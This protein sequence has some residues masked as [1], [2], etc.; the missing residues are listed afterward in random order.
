MKTCLC[1]TVGLM[2][3]LT[4][5]FAQGA[6]PHP[7]NPAALGVDQRL[8]EGLF[9]SPI[10]TQPRDE[11]LGEYGVWASG[12]DYKVSF[13]DG[14]TFFPLVGSESGNLPWRW[15]TTKIAV[16][17][18]PIA[19]VSRVECSHG[20]WRYEYRFPGITEAYDVLPNAV[21]Q[22]FV[23][24]RRPVGTGDLTIEGAIT[25]SLVAAPVS[26][27]VQ[28]L[29]F[30]D[31]GGKPRVRYG[32]AMAIAAD[33]TSVPV[34]TQ[35]DGAR[36][37]LVVPG[38]WLA[39]AAMPVVVDP[40][41]AAI[42]LSTAPS[43]ADAQQASIHRQDETA[44]NTVVAF[45]RQFA[46]GDFDVF[47]VSCMADMSSPLPWMN[48]LT[49]NWSSMTP[50]VT[51]VAG[52]DRWVVTTWRHTATE[53]RLRAYFHARDDSALNSGTFDSSYNPG[54]EHVSFPAMG[55]TSHPTV[56]TFAVAVYRMD[57]FFGNSASS[58]IHA[59]TVDA[60]NR[61]ITGRQIVEDVLDSDNPDVNCQVGWGENGWIV[62]YAARSSA[63]DDFDVYCRRVT[64]EPVA[65]VSSRVLVGPD[66]LG[67]KMRVAVQGWDGRYL[68]AMLQDVG[69]ETNGVHFA[70][71]VLTARL[72][73]SQ[74]GGPT[75]APHRTPVAMVAQ[76]VTHLALGFDGTSRSHWCL[77]YDSG[78]F[79][80]PPV[81]SWKRLG[82]S[83]GMVEQGSLG[84]PRFHPAVSWNG[85]DNEFQIVS[86]TSDA[87]GTLYA[88]RLQQ[89]PN[90]WHLEYGA[91]CG[92]GTIGSSTLPIMG[93]EFYRVELAAAPPQQIALLCFSGGSGSVSLAPIGAANCVMNLASLDVTLAA[94]TD[95]TGACGFTFAL[96][97]APAFFGD[98]YWQFVYLWP[99]APT[100]LAIGATKGL[101]ASVR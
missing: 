29:V 81:T 98:L 66:S 48:D 89:S 7:P 52:V 78:G 36:V 8:G 92:P 11:R 80:S 83:G 82:H 18:E 57:P 16:G 5:L 10:H 77:L 64:I 75:V 85:V 55:G 42:T 6:I 91:A 87:V 93:S 14:F 17:E 54:T 2:A 49:A 19:D 13:H 62:A 96:P 4:P 60:W 24:S 65:T 26:A 21:E 79:T 9:R 31:A 100:P 12:D 34:T 38:G 47:A 88:S 99:A 95:A 74:T 76:E 44:R 73:W 27:A 30:V 23:L 41:T 50:D 69:V 1:S 70:R 37:R 45:V 40:L 58:Q 53:D 33:G 32:K 61:V 20:D 46:A 97:D 22:T 71:N 39:T 59:A 101:R 15:K 84:A 43:G 86:C 68:V 56:G 25:T 51:F 67:D 72:D 90:A 63:I 94:V 35:F 3:V 28:E